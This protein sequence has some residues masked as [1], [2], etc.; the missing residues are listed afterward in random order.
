M[1]R[2]KRLYSPNGDDDFLAR[3]RNGFPAWD[4]GTDSMAFQKGKMPKQVAKALRSKWE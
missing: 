2:L 4:V 1:T 3:L